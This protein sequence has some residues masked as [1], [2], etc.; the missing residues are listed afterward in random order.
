MTIILM[1]TIRIDNGGGSYL[2]YREMFKR[3]DFSVCL[4]GKISW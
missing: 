4:K 2:D 1:L 3:K